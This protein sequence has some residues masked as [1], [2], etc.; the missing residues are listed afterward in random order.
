MSILLIMGCISSIF[1]SAYYKLTDC[2]HKIEEVNE[3]ELCEQVTRCS[4][5]YCYTMASISVTCNKKY[6]RFR[7]K[8]YCSRECINSHKNMNFNTGEYESTR[9]I[10]L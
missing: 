8:L 6:L 9:Y 2:Y 1:R 7:N 3:T 10:D 5:P 4:Y